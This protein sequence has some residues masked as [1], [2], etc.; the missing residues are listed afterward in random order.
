MEGSSIQSRFLQARGTQGNESS[1]NDRFAAE[2]L[3]ASPAEVVETLKVGVHRC[4]CLPNALPLGRGRCLS[5]IRQPALFPNGERASAARKTLSIAKAYT[6]AAGL[7]GSLD[8]RQQIKKARRA[9]LKAQKSP[10]EISHR[11]IELSQK[12]ASRTK[13]SRATRNST[14]KELAVLKGPRR[15]DSVVSKRLTVK[16]TLVSKSAYGA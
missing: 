4:A 15:T 10:S 2:C 9:R 8:R 3:C 16:E 5:K 14:Q 1:R 13:T 11:D 12:R 6:P 7:N